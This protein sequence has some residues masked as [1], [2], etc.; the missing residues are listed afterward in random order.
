MSLGSAAHGAFS[1]LFSNLFISLPT[2]SANLKGQTYIVSGSNTGLGFEAS[3]HLSRLGAEKLIMAV[4]SLPKGETAR[5]EILESTGREPDSIEV[6]ELDMSSYDSVKSFA[7]R[8]TSTLTRV[9]GVLANAGIMVDV[10]RMSEDNESTITVNVV[11]TFLLFLLLLPKFRDS[12]DK[13]N[14]APRFTIVNSALHYMA[15]LKELDPE[16]VPG[17]IFERLNNK[18]LADMSA[19]YNVSKL[20]VVYA[21]RELAER[22]KGSTSIVLNAPNPSYCKSALALGTAQGRSAGGKAFE[23]M[24]ARSTEEG[25]RA[26]VHG[27]VSGPETNGQYLTNCHVQTPSSSVTCPKGVRIQKKFVDELVAKLVEIAPEAASYI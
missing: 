5:R 12:A 9:D 13:F 3:R 7:A 22:L 26:L 1:T 4:R 27:V 24:L 11:S 6:W 8:V 18:E 25:S 16:R 20:L 15:S 23:K 14:I 17:S 19:R 10:F 21:V 2:P